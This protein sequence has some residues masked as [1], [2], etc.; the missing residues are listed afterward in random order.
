[1]SHLPSD[2][3]R[4]GA[5]YLLSSALNLVALGMAAL[6]FARHRTAARTADVEVAGKGP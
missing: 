1:V 2:D 3:W 4:V 5:P 6:Y